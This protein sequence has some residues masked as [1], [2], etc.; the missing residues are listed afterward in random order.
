VK[1]APIAGANG[2]ID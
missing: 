1:G 2:K